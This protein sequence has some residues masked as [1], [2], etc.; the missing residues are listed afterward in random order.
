LS[1][2]IPSLATF[3]PKVKILDHISFQLM[4]YRCQ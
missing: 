2:R 3:G 1:Q 4:Q